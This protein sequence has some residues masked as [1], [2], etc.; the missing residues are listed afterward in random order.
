MGRSAWKVLLRTIFIISQ[1]EFE[2]CSRTSGRLLQYAAPLTIRINHHFAGIA[3]NPHAPKGL[4]R[5]GVI[6][7]VAMPR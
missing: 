1:T 6:C 4:R 7:F 3:R 2:W 5:R